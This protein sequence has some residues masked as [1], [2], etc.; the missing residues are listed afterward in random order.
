MPRFYFHCSDGFDLVGDR[1]GVEI[2]GSDVLWS[3]LRAAARLMKA[4][5]SYDGWSAWTVSV[6]DE[7]GS[8]VETVPFPANVVCSDAFCPE[9]AFEKW[10][11]PSPANLHPTGS[12]RYH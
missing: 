7:R 1:E 3:A 2:Q 9:E 4:L 12:T 11:R 6:H 8:L 5:P 10:P